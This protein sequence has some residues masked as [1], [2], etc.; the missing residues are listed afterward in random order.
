[1]ENLPHNDPARVGRPRR[2]VRLSIPYVVAACLAAF[3]LFGAPRM[4]DADLPVGSAQGESLRAEVERVLSERATDGGAGRQLERE[5]LVRLD[6]GPSDGETVT[7]RQSIPESDDFRR[8]DAGDDVYVVR[9]EGPGGSDVYFITEP[10]RH[11][12][13]LVLA[14]VFVV[15]LLV[16]GRWHGLRSLVA[17]GVSLLVIVQFVIP[18]ILEGHSPELIALGGAAMIVLGSVYVGHGA[19]WKTHVAVVG[20]LAALAV[21]TALA[22]AFIRFGELSGLTSEE[23]NFLQIQSA[24]TINARGLLLAGVIIGALGVLDDVAIAQSSTVWELARANRLWGM[25]ML[26]GGAMNVGRDHIASTVNTLVLAYAGASLPLLLLLAVNAEDTAVLVNREF[27]A[28]EI[29]RTLV[30]TIGIIT[31]VPLTTGLAAAVATRMTAT[32]AGDG[33]AGHDHERARP[34]DVVEERHEAEARPG[35]SP[36]EPGAPAIPPDHLRWIPKQ[37]PDPP[38]NER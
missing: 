19:G 3:L 7:V 5:L 33:A 35:D 34:S 29:V 2:M 30:G 16:V 14:A 1:M 13:L 8:Y 17:L 25:R 11:T 10:I 31:A 12:A 23:A 4:F 32:A 38:D 18:G 6:E 20:M 21:T 27:L 9:S 37:R 36:G 22:F 28:V 15:A 26:F 24:G